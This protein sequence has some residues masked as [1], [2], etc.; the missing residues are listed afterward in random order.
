MT[1]DTEIYYVFVDVLR[2]VYECGV[3]ISD[4]RRTDLI[5]HTTHYTGIFLAKPEL[6]N[7]RP[8]AK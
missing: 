5:R 6:S 7:T 1:D 3:R 2:K 8:Y 4:R